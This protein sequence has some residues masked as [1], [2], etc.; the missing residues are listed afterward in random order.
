MRKVFGNSLQT[1]L[2]FLLPHFWPQVLTE[3]K[4]DISIILSS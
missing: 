4:E 3:A 1:I 2:I